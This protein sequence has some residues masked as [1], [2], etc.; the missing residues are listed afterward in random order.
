MKIAELFSLKVYPFTLQSV[1]FE[2]Y[3]RA[4]KVL[5]LVFRKNSKNWDT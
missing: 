3:I 5:K 2:T 1:K 4:S